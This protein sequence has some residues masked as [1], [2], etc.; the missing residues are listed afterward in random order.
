MAYKDRTLEP[1][2]ERVSGYAAARK[3]EISSVIWEAFFMPG[4]NF[5]PRLLSANWIRHS[6]PLHSP[7][8]CPKSPLGL[9]MR[10]TMKI[11]NVRSGARSA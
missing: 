3:S 11:R 2:V 6:P 4:A 8:L 1:S 7:I 5:H 9:T 10:I